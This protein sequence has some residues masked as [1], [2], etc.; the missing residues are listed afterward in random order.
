M[1]ESS[2]YKTFWEHLDEFRGTLIKII[3]CL[4]VCSVLA[5]CFKDIL[6]SLVLYPQQPSFVTYSILNIKP[7]KVELISTE[8]TAQMM[9]HIKT[10]FMFGVVMSSPYIIKVLFSFIAPALYENEKKY[11]I[12]IILSA[13]IMFLMGIALNYF[14]IFPI[15]WNFLA[16][17]QV[18][19]QV[20]NMITLQS[21]MDT[22]LM[23]SLVFGI[24]F[25][26][27]VLS[28]ILGKLGFI[29]SR[30]MKKYRK[31]TIVVVLILA[32]IITPTSDIFTLLIVSLPIWL[33][34][35]ISIF[36]VKA[37]EKR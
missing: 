18:S 26:I 31:H 25:E 37:V 33:L 13:Y 4:V 14:L 3:V 8:L 5:F 10:A 7:I 16:N 11:S 36:I 15:T 27:P 32:A 6:F 21:Y 24:M 2:N 28:W 23:L 20:K 1:S 35:E 29:K 9:I 22:L 34:Y 17:Y 12:H 30:V 19:V